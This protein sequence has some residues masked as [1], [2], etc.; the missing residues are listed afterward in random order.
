MQ[1]ARSFNQREIGLPWK[2]NLLDYAQLKGWGCKVPADKL[3]QYLKIHLNNPF[4]V[5]QLG[6]SKPHSSL[7]IHIKVLEFSL[8]QPKINLILLSLE[9]LMVQIWIGSHHLFWLK[10]FLIFLMGHQFKGH[11]NSNVISKMVQMIQTDH[12]VQILPN[13]T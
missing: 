4:R 10:I 2:F 9:W 12:Q 6:H 5:P 11:N 8:K 3:F 1:R 13:K 7:G